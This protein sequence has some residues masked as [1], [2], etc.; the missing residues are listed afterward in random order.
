MRPSSYTKSDTTIANILAAAESLFLK[1]NYADVTVTE[2]AEAADVTKGALY[3]HFQS[4]EDVY[5][6]ML[7]KD[8]EEKRRLLYQATEM[9]GDCRARLYRLTEA[10][11]NLPKN[12]RD[13]IKLVRRDIN[14]FK[15]PTRNRLIRAYQAALP[16]LIE[17]IITDGIENGELQPA[18][19]R[20]LSWLFVGMVEVT[21]APYARKVFGGNERILNYVLDLFFHGAASNTDQQK[22]LNVKRVGANS[23]PHVRKS[24]N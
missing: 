16:E 14:I 8:L 4:K 3:H 5:L 11:L 15:D 1:N 22:V 7:Y 10:F 17:E 2:I 23:G 13:L 19:P 6:T 24:K 9:D 20:V 21:L 12:K 18:D